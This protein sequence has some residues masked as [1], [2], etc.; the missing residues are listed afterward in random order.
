MRVKWRYLVVVGNLC[1]KFKRKEEDKL[2]GYKDI[3]GFLD[4]RVDEIK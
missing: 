2:I 4:F 3:S 1:L